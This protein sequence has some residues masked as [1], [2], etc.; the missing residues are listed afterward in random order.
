M[1]KL[2]PIC[3]VSLVV[4]FIIELRS[5]CVL[6]QYGEKIYIKKDKIFWILLSIIMI[7]FV[8]LRKKYNDTFVYRGVYESTSSNLNDF[9]NLNVM[10]GDNPGYTFL[11]FLF[12]SLDIS[13]TSYLLIYA[14]VTIYI[15]M[16]FIRKYSTK[17]WLSIYIF[18]VSGSFIFAMAGM[19]QA[20]AIAFDLVAVDCAIN[21]KWKAFVL[22]VLIGMLFHPYS[23]MFLIVPFLRFTPG[24]KKT[25]ILLGTFAVLGIVMPRLLGSIV[26]ITSALGEEYSIETFTG[27]GVNFYRFLVCAVPIILILITRKILKNIED[28]K[29][30]IILNLSI[31]NGEIM[32]MA[33]FGTANYFGRLANYFLIFQ[34]LSIPYLLRGFTD[35]SKKILIILCVIMYAMF[36]FYQN[37]LITPFDSAYVGISFREYLASIL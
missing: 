11:R 21:K 1:L 3:I 24:N 20:I 12:R 2:V 28:S 25:Y 36:F 4:S 7:F 23:L 16:W 26:G 14:A 35:K 15:Y 10:I 27:E 6:D 5:E 19:K 29:W 8:G 33:L 22:W 13:T 31:L 30:N 34:T 18:I 17:V 9:F 32:F 37:V